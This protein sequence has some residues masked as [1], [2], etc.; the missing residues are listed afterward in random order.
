MSVKG[1]IIVYEVTWYDAH[2]DDGNYHSKYIKKISP[3][4]IRTVGYYVGTNNIDFKIAQEYH[5]N[6]KRFGHIMSIPHE[7]IIKKKVLK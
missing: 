5:K 6:T 4:I 2:F 1:K 3:W 7:M